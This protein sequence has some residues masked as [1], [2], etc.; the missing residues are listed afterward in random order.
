M[1]WDRES[2]SHQHTGTQRKLYA[3]CLTKHEPVLTSRL[4]SLQQREG[5]GTLCNVYEDAVKHK[6]RGKTNLSA[7]QFAIVSLSLARKLHT[8]FPT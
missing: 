1:Q 4:A 6:K 5:V 7:L 2:T 8:Q 3:G